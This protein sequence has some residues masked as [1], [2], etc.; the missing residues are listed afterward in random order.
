MRFIFGFICLVLSVH[1]FAWDGNV[2]GKI[3]SVDVTG[4]ENYGF[5]VSLDN[6]SKALCGNNH[7]WAYVNESFSNYQTYVAVLLAAKMA[8]KTVVLYTNQRGSN[9]YCE[10]GYISIR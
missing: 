3:Y 2:S 9:G 7:K 8:E 6:G 10:I 1:A 5:R 4:G